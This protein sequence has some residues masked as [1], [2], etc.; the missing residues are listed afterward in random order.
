MKN[1]YTLAII[2]SALLVSACNIDNGIDADVM[3]EK[4]SERSGIFYAPTEPDEAFFP[5]ADA[6]T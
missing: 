6:S 3:A 2:A 5:T 1:I 4:D